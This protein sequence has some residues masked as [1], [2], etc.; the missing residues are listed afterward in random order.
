MG[1]KNTV[2]NG[3]K[4]FSLNPCCDVS[5]TIAILN[6]CLCLIQYQGQKIINTYIPDHAKTIKE[7]F[8]L[9]ELSNEAIK[10]HNELLDTF[11][12]EFLPY[13]KADLD[14]GDKEMMIS[15]TYTDEDEWAERA[16][17]ELM[18]WFGDNTK[19]NPKEPSDTK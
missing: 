6:R 9:Y 10:L 13:L 15:A 8:N 12:L 2:C 5:R 14:F 11:Y 19:E 4:N 18:D 16:L 17:V 7:L 3:S 1:P